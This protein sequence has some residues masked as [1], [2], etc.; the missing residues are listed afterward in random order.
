[1][2]HMTHSGMLQHM[3]N[4]T[5]SN[6]AEISSAEAVDIASAAIPHCKAICR[7]KLIHSHNPRS[8]LD[9]LPTAQEC[10]HSS[11]LLGALQDL[12]S[13]SLARNILRAIIDL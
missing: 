6:R 7:M 8:A 12:I 11:F 2:K 10:H 1:M 13:S 5:T 4:N 3:A 9:S